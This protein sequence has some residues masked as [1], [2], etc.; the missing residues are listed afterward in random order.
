MAVFKKK[1]VYPV[2]PL[3]RPEELVKTTNGKVPAKLL[4]KTKSGADLYTKAAVAYDAL[5]D[6]ALKAGFEFKSV[7]GYR[8]YERQLELFKDRYTTKDL[9]RKPQVTRKFEGKTWF[10]KPGKSPAGTPGTSNHG[11]ALAVDLAVKTPKGLVSLGSV[12]KAVNWLCANAP[13]YGFYLQVSDP[14]SPEFEIWHWQYC[15]GDS[16]PEALQGVKPPVPAKPTPPKPTPPVFPGILKKGSKGE[17]VKKVQRTIKTTVDGDFGPQTEKAV[18]AWQKA[19][20]LAVTGV[21]DA[22]TWKAMFG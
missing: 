15:A 17:N 19:R 14:K 1:P 6:A 12:P 7:G 13:R 10:L 16:T 22:K 8:P 11:L 9:G 21:V 20:G 2:I 4:R 5:H 3:R 18:K